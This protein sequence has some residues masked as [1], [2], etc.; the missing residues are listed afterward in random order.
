M[1]SIESL[2]SLN[3]IASDLKEKGQPEVKA[4]KI[5]TDPRE[6]SPEVKPVFWHPWCGPFPA[7]DFFC[8]RD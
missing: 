6:K 2:K 4:V 7:S 3:K 8:T 5:F 1:W